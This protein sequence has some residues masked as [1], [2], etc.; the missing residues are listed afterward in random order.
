MRTS[1]EH[2][3][4]FNCISMVV[5]LSWFL[6]SGTVS[7]QDKPDNASSMLSS[8]YEPS[9][10]IDL[11][12]GYFT[13]RRQTFREIYG[14]YF[15][16]GLNFQHHINS[17]LSWNLRTEF[18]RLHEKG[19]AVKYWSLSETSMIIYALS[20]RK[21]L[22]PVIGGGIGL[23][24]RNVVA[25]L[26]RIGASGESIGE[27]TATQKEL[28]AVLVAMTGLDLHVS[29]AVVFGGRFYFDYHPLGDPSTGDFGDTGG[30]HFTFRLG[31]K[32]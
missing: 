25:S 8:I 11:E 19:S 5:A 21:T 6:P 4:Y 10:R 13:C 26:V 16:Y 27:V 23:T 7:A 17:R 22:V 18:I 28:S 9:N 14:S 31:R 30:Y 20:D 32:F 15:D 1:I 24:L 2:V 3:G 29:D 12:F